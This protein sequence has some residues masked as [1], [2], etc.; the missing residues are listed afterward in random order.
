M[1]SIFTM[2]IYYLEKR[3]ITVLATT[4]NNNEFENKEMETKAYEKMLLNFPVIH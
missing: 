3:V 4:W 1:K 2:P